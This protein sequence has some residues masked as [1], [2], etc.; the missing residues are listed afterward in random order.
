MNNINTDSLLWGDFVNGQLNSALKIEFSNQ[1]SNMQSETV[2]LDAIKSLS[3]VEKE[4]I[5]LRIMKGYS[6]TD[7]SIVLKKSEEAVKSLQFSCINK[8]ASHLQKI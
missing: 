1:N 8:I 6:I 4:V 2:I 3:D 7:A 5:V